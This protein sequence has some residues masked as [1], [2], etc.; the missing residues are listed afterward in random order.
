MDHCELCKNY[1]IKKE[2]RNNKFK[3][4]SLT[5]YTHC[6]IENIFLIMI[7]VKLLIILNINF[8]VFNFTISVNLKI[9]NIL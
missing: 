7:G 9:F 4:F 5:I 8:R 3:I 2:R 6:L 1:Y